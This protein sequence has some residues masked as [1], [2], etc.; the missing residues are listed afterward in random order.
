MHRYRSALLA[1]KSHP[2][3][4]V[5]RNRGMFPPASPT[6]HQSFRFGALDLLYR[7]SQFFRLMESLPTLFVYRASLAIHRA[8]P[9]KWI[10]NV[11]RVAGLIWNCSCPRWVLK[12]EL[13]ISQFLEELVQRISI[14]RK[15]NRGQV[16]GTINNLE[17]EMRNR[18]VL[19]QSSSRRR[20]R[21]VWSS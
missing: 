12:V 19:W 8:K 21:K 7:L 11:I 5:N 14:V 9:L 6:V 15:P 2:E 17:Y 4:G 3:V 13:P 1:K 10:K 20:P 16:L 18:G